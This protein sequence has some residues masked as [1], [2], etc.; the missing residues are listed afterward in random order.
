MRKLGK[1]ALLLVVFGWFCPVACQIS[2]LQWSKS[3]LE[4]NGNFQYVACATL[5]FLSM[6]TALIGVVLFVVSSLKKTRNRDNKATSVL[7][8]IFGL[9]FLIFMVYVSQ[10]IQILNYGAF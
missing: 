7:S 2:G 4:G 8:M 10:T 5:L 3:V 9:P 6:I 1:L